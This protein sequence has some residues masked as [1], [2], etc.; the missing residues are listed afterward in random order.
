MGGLAERRGR[1]FAVSSD[2]VFSFLP[3]LSSPAFWLYFGKSYIF[4]LDF[5]VTSVNSSFSPIGTMVSPSPAHAAG[6]AAEQ[7]A[8]HLRWSG[9]MTQVDG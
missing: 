1:V 8:G 6:R 2:K 5:P 3:A 7:F 4:F 9:K